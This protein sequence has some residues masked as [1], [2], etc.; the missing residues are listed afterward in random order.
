MKGTGHTEP[1]NT[2]FM[3]GVIRNP[4]P[5]VDFLCHTVV[6]LARA[7]GSR[8]PPTRPTGRQMWAA[9][10]DPSH[11]RK[12]VCAAPARRDSLPRGTSGST[13]RVAAGIDPGSAA[14]EPRGEPGAAQGPQG[15]GGEPAPRVLSASAF[16]PPERD[17][18]QGYSGR[19]DQLNGTSLKNADDRGHGAWTPRQ[20]LMGSGPPRTERAVAFVRVLTCLGCLGWDRSGWN[21]PGGPLAPCHV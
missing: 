21:L 6:V 17:E 3:G 15:G 19:W 20:E 8:K 1:M 7:L 14:S 18:E 5:R 16:W 11:G 13:P 10:L 2:W 12:W 9:R 4:S